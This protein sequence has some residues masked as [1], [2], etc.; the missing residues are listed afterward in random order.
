MNMYN[1]A[2]SFS[3]FSTIKTLEIDVQ[4]GLLGN[5]LSAAVLQNGQ[6]PGCPESPVN[7]NPF[8]ISAYFPNPTRSN[9]LKSFS[10]M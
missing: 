6:S 2:L 9:L 4:N 7:I 5:N 8:E 3:T 10:R 1:S